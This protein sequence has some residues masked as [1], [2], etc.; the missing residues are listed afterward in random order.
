M[1]INSAIKGA[2]VSASEIDPKIQNDL[3]NQGIVAP[4][5][6]GQSFEFLQPWAAGGVTDPIKAQV[7]N[8][9]F[10]SNT[11]DADIASLRSASEAA[12]EAIK[13]QYAGERERVGIAGAATQG[14]SNVQ[15]RITA[16]TGSGLGADTTLGNIRALEMEAVNRSLKNLKAAEDQAIA[17]NDMNLLNNIR[18]AKNDEFTRSMELRAAE[19]ADRGLMLQELSTKAGISQAERGLEMQERQFEFSKEQFAKTFGLDQKQFE[20]QT[21]QFNTQFEESKKQF[22]ITKALDLLSLQ[23][24]QANTLFNQQIALQELANSTPAGTKVSISGVQM[25]PQ[26]IAD[27]FN[28]IQFGTEVGVFDAGT[29]L[30][31]AQIGS[32]VENTQVVTGRKVATGDSAGLTEEEKQIQ[33][34]Q[35][36]AFDLI[37]KLDD[38]EVSVSW[39]TAF[40][41]LK[42]KYPQASDATINAVLGGGI[43]YNPE[44][45]EF[46]TEGAYGRAN[47]KK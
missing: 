7:N 24:N 37:Q 39:A 20:E 19:R 36:D 38:P 17:T 45:G 33:A 40:D 31:G 3:I 13:A 43:P 42:A 27:L 26:E 28:A 29:P 4:R 21:R 10:A 5:E 1:A 30:T 18:T 8:A 6:G 44:T 34:F 14:A 22:G 23:V 47:V 9:G 11:L 32:L 41:A 16:G 2:Q 35:A 15:G 46:D 12:K 25:G